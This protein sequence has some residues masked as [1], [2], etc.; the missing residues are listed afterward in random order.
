MNGSMSSKK[1][2]VEREGTTQLPPPSPDNI[3]FTPSNDINNTTNSEGRFRIDGERQI[4]RPAAIHPTGR[5]N[6]ESN[7]G[8][9]VEAVTRP[10]QCPICRTANKITR[11]PSN[12]WKCTECGHT[13]N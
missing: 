12:Q 13:W 1:F 6:S 7:S 5:S 2:I 11:L 4:E 9:R 10:K 8:F 3:R